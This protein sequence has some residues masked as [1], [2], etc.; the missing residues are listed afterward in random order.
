MD[1]TAQTGKINKVLCNTLL[2]CACDHTHTHTHTY[3]HAQTRKH[4]VA[5]CYTGGGASGMAFVGLVPDVR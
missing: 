3:K 5:H 4:N 1:M 2:F